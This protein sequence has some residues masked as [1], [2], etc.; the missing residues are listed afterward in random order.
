MKIRT[1]IQRLTPIPNEEESLKGDMRYVIIHEITEL[2]FFL[3]GMISE[4]DIVS[5]GHMGP[6][7]GKTFGRI[8][9]T[10]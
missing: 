3:S 9:T 8:S 10:L 4:I 5:L 6:E 2:P 1:P 7:G